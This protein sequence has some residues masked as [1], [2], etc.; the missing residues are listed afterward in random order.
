MARKDKMDKKKKEFGKIKYTA[1]GQKVVYVGD[2]NNSEKIVQEIMI[3]DG[4][5]IE[6]ERKFVVT[7]LYDKPV[8]SWKEKKLEEIDRKYAEEYESKSNQLRVLK[9]SFREACALFEQKINYVESAT[10]KISAKTLNLLKDYITGKIKYIV[11][12][13]FRV[14]IVEFVD[15]NEMYEQGLRL[16][17]FFGMDDGSFSWKINDYCDGSGT[18]REFYPCRSLKEAKKTLEIIINKKEIIYDQ[19]VEAARQYGLKISKDKVAEYRERKISEYNKNIAEWSCRIEASL[20]KI[21]EL[22]A[23]DIG[24]A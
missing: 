12:A 24:K 20:L 22:K 8:K 10:D 1:D 13:G 4:V 15:F 16:V 5:E 7:S 11:E 18:D 17:S 3:S 6:S 14:R 9:D 21:E 23:L 2:F 19:D